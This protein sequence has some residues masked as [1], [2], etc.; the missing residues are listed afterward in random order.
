MKHIY[1]TC[2]FLLSAF[3]LANASQ[4]NRAK[5]ILDHT[6]DAYRKAGG[7]HILFGGTQQGILL[8]CS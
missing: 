2:L 5:T 7:I 3:A 1:I 4:D 8:S 6:A